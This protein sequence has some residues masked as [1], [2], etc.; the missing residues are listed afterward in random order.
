MNRSFRSQPSP[1][2]TPLRLA[3]ALCTFVG[4]ASASGSASAATVTRH[5]LSPGQYPDARCNDGTQAAF[6]Y[7]PATTPA[8]ADNWVIYLEGGGG[9]SDLDGCEDRLN[10]APHK[11]STGCAAQGDCSVGG[12]PYGVAQTAIPTTRDL[13]GLFEPQ[14]GSI[15][16]ANR[17]LIEYCSSDG[18]SGEGGRADGSSFGFTNLDGT[19]DMEFHGHDIVSAV[20]D[21]L[22][23][24]P[25]SPGDE[26]SI[27]LFAGGS[28]G[29]VGAVRNLD[30]VA[31]RLPNAE[32]RGFFDS[33]YHGPIVANPDYPSTSDYP[34][35]SGSALNPPPSIAGPTITA[36]Y[37]LFDAYVDDTCA[38]AVAPGEEAVCMKVE[39]L[40]IDDFIETPYTVYQSFHDF[41][42]RTAA[43]VADLLTSQG[44]GTGRANRNQCIEGAVLAF[45]EALLQ[46]APA[47][48]EGNFLHC[49][50]KHV[51]GPTTYAVTNTIGGDNVID[52]LTHWFSG[53]G[54]LW[55]TDSSCL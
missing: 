34:C 4:L 10:D 8:F 6:Y 11:M 28:A 54:N 2:R 27:V 29:S 25:V 19:S 7:A 3:A 5:V 15:G 16:Q 48:Y 36:K 12:A 9:C 26:D 1:V 52:M 42:A 46:V 17:I 23:Q 38:Q 13:D 47:S 18:W 55:Y 40:M 41:N 31:D 45:D 44:L 39:K 33:A 43:S 21:H 49:Q 14:N 22:E 51:V 20:L 37:D 53:A 35:T 32:V 24:L 50:Q 30:Y